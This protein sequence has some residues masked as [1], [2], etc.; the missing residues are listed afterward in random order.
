VTTERV[1]GLA[2][3]KRQ[4][5]RDELAKAALMLLAFQGYDTTTVE[6][7]VAAAGVSRRTFFRYFRSKEDVIIQFY[8]DMG[9]QLRL[10]F[11]SRPAQE[12]LAVALRQAFSVLVVPHFA[13]RE[14]AVRLAR[15]TLD[16][17]A[18]LG[19]YLERQVNWRTELAAELA[20]RTGLTEPTDMRPN[21]LASIALAAFD[22]ALARWVATDGAEDFGAVLD[23]A[24]TLVEPSLRL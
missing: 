12:P 5:V 2:E 17:P 24:F 1:P 23:E 15:L 14:K 7:I 19:R 13:H 20:R 4:L 18:L 11:A 3:R 10:A 8:S 21:L 9:D 22:S 16:T 6:Q